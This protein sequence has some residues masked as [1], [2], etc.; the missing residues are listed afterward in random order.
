MTATTYSEHDFALALAP[1]QFSGAAAIALECDRNPTRQACG[2][3]G[4]GGTNDCTN[5]VRL[6]DSQDGDGYPLSRNPSSSA[7]SRQRAATA[8]GKFARQIAQ[9]LPVANA[10]DNGA[11]NT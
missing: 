7:A 6:S 5:P 9:V 2:H 3:G 8:P 10:L 4:P 1:A 11:T